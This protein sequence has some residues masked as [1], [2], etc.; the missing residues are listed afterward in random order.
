MEQIVPMLAPGGRL[1]IFAGIYP[2]DQ[3]HLD[4]NLI[5][6]G[7]FVITGSADS[8]PKNMNKALEFIRVRDS[9]YRIVNQPFAPSGRIGKR[10]RN[11]KKSFRS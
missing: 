3:I 9:K 10:F 7:E 6:Y 1:N 8:T 11:R 2:K 5:H 4:P